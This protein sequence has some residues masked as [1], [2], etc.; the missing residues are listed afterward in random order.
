LLGLV[1]RTDEKIRTTA[2]EGIGLAARYHPKLIRGIVDR[3]LW[4]MQNDSGAN[5]VS[6][7]LVLYAIARQNP[8]LLVPVISKIVITASDTSLYQGLCDTLRH[9]ASRCPGVVGKSMT[10]S[11]IKRFAQGGCCG[12]V[13]P[14]KS[15]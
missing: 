2:A 4:A 10:E 3:L 11:L 8:E 5:A 15:Q 9:V 1:Y 12:P 7:P 13:D 14:Y 6:A